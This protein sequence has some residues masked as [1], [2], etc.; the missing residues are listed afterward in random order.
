[1][2]F[3]TLYSDLVDSV[4]ELIYFLREPTSNLYDSITRTVRGVSSALPRALPTPP[5][6]SRPVSF[7]SFFAGQSEEPTL[8]SSPPTAPVAPA[9]QS[10][11]SKSSPGY[12][13]ADRQGAY[14]SKPV[15]TRNRRQPSAVS[16]QAAVTHHR[17]AD[18]VSEL[19]LEDNASAENQEDATRYGATV[20]MRGED[21]VFSAWDSL[22]D[23]RSQRSVSPSLVQYH[24]SP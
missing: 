13:P 15:D 14:L 1:M 11:P 19:D 3:H 7:G 8:P 6:V 16:S 4:R 23:R 24:C 20:R 5:R 9:Q 18:E 17:G 12:A 21:V 2:P 22:S 10:T